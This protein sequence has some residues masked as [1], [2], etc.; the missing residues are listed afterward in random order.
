VCVVLAS[1]GYPGAYETGVPIDGVEAA[2][3]TGAVV[4]HAGTAR[5]D[6]RLVTAGGRV[7]GVTAVGDDVSGAIDAAYEAVGR[8]RFEGVHFR[9]DIGRR[10]AVAA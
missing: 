3:A 1:G 7:L 5:R 9:R 4:F 10:R 6:G 8:I 2:E